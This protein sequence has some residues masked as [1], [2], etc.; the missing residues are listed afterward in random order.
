MTTISPG[1]P[2]LFRS[3]ILIVIA[4]CGGGGIAGLLYVTREEPPR[5]ERAA[6]PPLVESL[7]VRAEQV[8]ERYA[9]Y[10]TARPD[11]TARLAS[12]VASTVIELVNNIEAGSIVIDGQSLIRLDDREYRYALQRASALAASDQASADE[13]VAEAQILEKLIATADEELRVARDERDRLSGLF[14]R[15]LAAKKEFDFA[16]MAYQQTRRVLQGYQMQLAK[17]APRQ[18]RFAASKMSREA[19]VRLAELN[20]E[21][22][23]I[24]APFGGTIETLS[25]EIGDRVAPGSVVLT[26]IDPAHV[27]IPVRLPASV[28]DRISLGA[29]CRIDCES[30]PGIAW[31]GQVARIAASVDEQTRT[32][33]VYLDVDNANQARPLVPGTF[34]RAEVQGPIHQNRILVPRVAIREG[35]VLVAEDGVVCPRPVR[36]ERLIGDRALIEGDVQSGERVILSHLDTLASGTPIRVRGAETMSSGAGHAAGQAGVGRAP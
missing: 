28:H 4:L 31:E 26:L 3:I 1:K 10:G 35:R 9:G 25:V 15:G 33:P 6:P 21:R 7:V 18:A 20:I 2:R 36:V 24:T 14:E 13:V 23:E 27:E 12:E 32:F 34:V 5:R 16:I 30:M 22:C 11:R 8:T 29:P 19:E 17:M